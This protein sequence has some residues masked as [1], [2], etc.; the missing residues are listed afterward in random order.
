MFHWF[1]WKDLN[2]LNDFGLLIGKMPAIVRAA[3]RYD[4]VSIPGRPGSL[5]LLEG[6]DVYDSYPKEVT[7]IS[8]NDNPKLQQALSWLRGSG[9]VVF[10]NETD[11]AY[12][13]RIVNEVRFDRIGNDLLQAKIQ[14]L[15]EPLK[16]ARYGDTAVT[17]TS[18]GTIYNP[19]DVASKPVVRIVGSGTKE[20]TIGGTAMTFTSLNGT[21][22]SP[23]VVDC[24]AGIVTKGGNLWT[25]KVTGDFW[26][27]PVGSSAVLPASSVSLTIDPRWRWV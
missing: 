20:I 23:V 9:D 17:M 7:V 21:S 4:T 10:S 25:N 2:S 22:S 6:E 12:E 18:S 13:A 24:D 15:V 1:I 27:I 8:R 5:I 19:G 3:E 16:K 14:F 26:R 11:Y